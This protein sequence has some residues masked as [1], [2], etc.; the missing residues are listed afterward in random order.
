MLFD[1]IQI[2]TMTLRNRMMRSA[3]AEVLADEQGTPFPQ[4]SSMYAAL[5]KGGVGLI[6]T[7]HMYVQASGKAHPGMT[8]IHDDACIE[9]LAT[10]AD[11]VH[12]EGGKI[13]VQINH[14]G[15]QV[16]EGLVADPIAPTAVDAKPPKPAAKEASIDE[17]EDLIDAY[18]QAARRGKRAGFDA[19]QIHAAHGYLVNQFL[20]P[21]ANRRN[22]EWG[23]SFDHRL[24]FLER[25]AYAIRVE[26]GE[27]YPVLI[28]LGARDEA[29][30]GLCL[31]DGAE[32]IRRLPEMGIDAVEI[33]GGIADSGAFN[34]GAGVEAGVNEATFRPWATRLRD[35]ASL[36]VM[37][38]GGMRSQAVM[39]D[40]LESGDADVISLCRPL[41]CE[42]D[43]PLRLQKGIQDAAACVSKNRCWAR[44]GDVGISCKC[45]GVVRVA[46]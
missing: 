30:D 21:L 18:A 38:V 8:G 19:V 42:P 6:V 17:I 15:R 9:A 29:D 1:P 25:I 24:R 14:G 7:G 5:A 37:L 46:A 44:K 11:A 35:A 23:G 39:E 13:A 26:V 34:I 43:L 20:S 27:E 40:V 33:S 10:L 28:K 36:P 16:R 31:D 22:D 4:L 45:P 2:G 3:T 41:I 32:I 12:A